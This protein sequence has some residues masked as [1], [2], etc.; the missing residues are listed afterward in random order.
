M[1]NLFVTLAVVVATGLAPVLATGN[2][3]GDPRSEA[4]FAK[5]FSGAENVKWTELEDQFKKVSFTLGGIRAEAYFSNEGELLGTVRNLFF[6]QL[7]LNVIQ[8]VNTKFSEPV[9]IEAKEITNADGTSYR[10]ILE[11]TDKRYN[12]KLNS[13]GEITDQQKVKIKK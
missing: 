2:Q 13:L 8:A 5:Q 9:I 10:I 11:H 6:S 7:P 12:L 1:K 3:P 4:I